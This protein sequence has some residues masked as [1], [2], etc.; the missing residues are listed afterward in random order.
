MAVGKVLLNLE[1]KLSRL[2][3]ANDKLIDAYE[4][5]N[6]TEGAEQFQQLLDEDAELID[7]ILTKTSDLKVLKIELERTRKELEIRNRDL[8]LTRE[9]S[10]H[11]SDI[12]I[13]SI[14]SQPSAHGPIK[15]PQ[16]EIMEMAGIL[17]PI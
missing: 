16:L 11:A 1:V 6:D 17:G 9:G 15:P 12:H 10:S 13:A 7:N 2:E 5:N 14:W 3:V 4:Q 8:H